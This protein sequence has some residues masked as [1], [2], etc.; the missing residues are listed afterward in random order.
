MPIIP[1]QA[2]SVAGQVDAVFLYILL[3]TIF[4]SVLIAALVIFFAIKYRKRPNAE[5]PKIETHSF[6]A[7]EIAWT[8]IPL[9]LSMV[10]FFWGA[11]VFLEQTSQT[12][13]A[14]E[15]FVVGKQWMWKFQHMNGRR[16]INHLHVPIGTD[17]KL[18]MG[19]EDVI[20]SFFVPAFRIKQDVVPGKLTTTWFR[21]T[22]PGEFRLFCAE[23]CGTN[24]S[25]MIGSVI[26]MP[27]AEFERWVSG[28]TG[29]TP[30]QAGKIVFEKFQCNTCH[31]PGQ[32]ARG[33]DFQG[34]FG[35]PVQLTTGDVVIADENYIRRSIMDPGAQV[36]A[37][38]QPIMPTFKNL[39]TEE[40]LLQLIAYIRSLGDQKTGSTGQGAVSADRATTAIQEAR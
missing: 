26:V 13:N 30:V 15:I 10:M 3:V 19:T 1:Q 9:G 18:I 22:K 21:A 17:V 24:H 36:V 31:V 6:L 4:F 34:L 2:S 16:E 29:A 38:F 7:L 35:K 23:Y 39:I 28:E 14:M 11:H 8:V 20:H 32:T 33:P 27:P 5:E 40:Q 12:K 25:R 37:G